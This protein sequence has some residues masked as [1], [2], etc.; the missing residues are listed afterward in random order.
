[1]QK[2]FD[3][4]LPGFNMLEYY[5]GV[6][7]GECSFEYFTLPNT[8]II[9]STGGDGTAFALW[10]KREN[11]FASA[12]VVILQPGSDPLVRLIARNVD[13]FISFLFNYE[14]TQQFETA[15]PLLDAEFSATVEQEEDELRT[16]ALFPMVEYLLK[17]AIGLK[18]KANYAEYYQQ[19][20]EECGE[21]QLQLNKSIKFD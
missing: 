13:D 14:N 19:L 6:A 2:A 4:E 1:M 18:P 12:P 3:S 17:P 7:F 15:T 8:K 11:D 10:F 16:K 20:Q 5:Y 9:G 21:L